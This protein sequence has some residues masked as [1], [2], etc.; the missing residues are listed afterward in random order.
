MEY[1][2]N[3]QSNKIAGQDSMQF[4]MGTHVRDLKNKVSRVIDDLDRKWA[5]CLG[6]QKNV[7]VAARLFINTLPPS[8]LPPY[9]S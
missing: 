2:V 7:K 5:G 9:S 4:V 8:F 6:I 3:I 1:V